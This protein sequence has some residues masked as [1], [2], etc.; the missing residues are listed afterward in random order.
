M[1]PLTHPSPHPIVSALLNRALLCMSLLSG[2]VTPIALSSSDA[3]LEDP[4]A[5]GGGGV[6]EDDPTRL[7]ETGLVVRLLVN[8]DPS[9]GNDIEVAY[10]NALALDRQYLLTT[11]SCVKGEVRYAEVK[12][13]GESQVTFTDGAPRLG[14]VSGVYVHPNHNPD[15]PINTGNDLAIL[16]LSNVSEESVISPIRFLNEPIESHLTPPLLRIGYQSEGLDFTL[17]RQIAL[18]TEASIESDV[19]TFADST[20]IGPACE[21]S[22]GLVLKLINNEP[23]VLALISHGEDACVSGG[24][25]SILGSESS[26]MFIDGVRALSPVYPMR[27]VRG[28]LLCKDHFDCY[29]SETC[30]SAYVVSQHRVITDALIDCANENQCEDNPQCLSDHCDEQYQACLNEPA[31]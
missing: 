18:G 6:G 27:P 17:A 3:G 29:G 15:V 30:L 25:G 24:S 13:G 26:R 7:I 5:G 20:S 1:Y 16:K 14:I 9:A 10:C 12:S 22:G 21:V 11:A 19:L 28:E 31:P 23:H 4:I 8:R 2:C